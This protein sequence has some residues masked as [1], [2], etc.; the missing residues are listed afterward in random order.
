MWFINITEEQAQ[1][2]LHTQQF[3]FILGEKNRGMNRDWSL[4]AVLSPLPMVSPKSGTWFNSC[5]WNGKKAAGTERFLGFQQ[6]WVDILILMSLPLLSALYFEIWKCGHHL[7]AVMPYGWGWKPINF[8]WLRR[9]LGRTYILDDNT[10][11]SK[12][13]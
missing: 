4:M 13:Y 1:C 12:Q 7:W 11:L 10:E 2:C 3:P 8:G 9:R 5:H 6:E